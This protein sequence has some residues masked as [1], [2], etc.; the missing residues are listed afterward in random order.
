MGP[1]RYAQMTLFHF[2]LGLYERSSMQRIATLLEKIAELSSKKETTLIEIDLMMD[3]TR[4]MYADL[5]EW[6]NK[7]AFTEPLTLNSEPTLAEMASA[8]EENHSTL[9]ESPEVTGPAV[10]LDSTSMNYESAAEAVTPSSISF[11][12]PPPYPASDIR[13][14]I[15][16]N[17]KY[18]FISELF[19][20]N[21]DAY[22]EVITEINAFD[23]E[24][25]AFYWLRNT[26]APQYG[27]KKDDES[28][29][30]LFGLVSQFF[31]ER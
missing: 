20:N 13:Q 12:T 16:I 22:E 19:G 4:V 27:W 31:R 6:R 5:L 8:M 9:D 23:T 29:V 30:S 26:V 2:H 15:G 11:S 25:E 21:K 24:D 17:D 10:E 7:I 3:Y 1:V 14:L 18:Q 28:L